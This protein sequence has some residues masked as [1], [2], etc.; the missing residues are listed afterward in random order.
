[1]SR[2]RARVL[3][4]HPCRFPPL[5][6]P[7]PSPALG[8]PAGPSPFS[9]GPGRRP[10]PRT[11]AHSRH[12]PFRFGSPQRAYLAPAPPGPPPG[13]ASQARPCCGRGRLPWE[14]LWPREP[15]GGGREGGRGA[16]GGGGR[17]GSLCPS[18]SPSFRPPPFPAA[19]PRAGAPVTLAGGRRV[20]SVRAPSRES[21]WTT[22]AP[23][24][25]SSSGE[26]RNASSPVFA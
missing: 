14:Q 6:P 8:L 18:P 16:R 13:P 7:G 12:G 9:Q 26:T 10:G 17:P 21:G 1:M 5:A 11:P 2:R 19:P 25:L 23:R 22:P 4:P 3:R 20:G 15:R 24:P